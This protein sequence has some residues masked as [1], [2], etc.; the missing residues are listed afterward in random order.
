[1]RVLRQENRVGRL[2]GTCK[3]L[4]GYR[5]IGISRSVGGRR[6]RGLF[7]KQRVHVDQ[8]VNA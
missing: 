3:L 5:K 7:K 1:M 2:V 6:S 8:N 4:K